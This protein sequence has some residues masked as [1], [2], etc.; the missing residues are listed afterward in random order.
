MCKPFQNMVG[1]SPPVFRSHIGC[2]LSLKGPDPCQGFIKFDTLATADLLIN[3][4][5]EGEAGGLLAGEPLSKLIPGASNQGGFRATG[6]RPGQEIRYS[7]H[8][9]GR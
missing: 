4:V 8:D 5:Y 9:S 2:I 6:K 1:S 7:I 3:A